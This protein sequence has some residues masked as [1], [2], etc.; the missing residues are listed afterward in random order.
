M[1]GK[2]DLG[3]INHD[4]MRIQLHDFGCYKDKTFEFGRE[5]SM[6]LLS[7]PSGTGKTTLI[8]AVFFALFGEGKKL[9]T[10]GK[11]SCTVELDFGDMK[12]FRS[13][14]PNRLVLNDIYEDEAAQQIINKRFGD[15]FKTSGYIQQNMMSSFLMMPANEKL[16]FLEKFGFQDT[17]PEKIKTKCKIYISECRDKHLSKLTQL[18]MTKNILEELDLP[19]EVKFPIKCT[20]KNRQMVIKNERTRYKNSL[21][22]YERASK[23]RR[24]YEKEINALGILEATLQSRKEVR[25]NALIKLEKIKDEINEQNYEGSEKL[26][27]YEER[28]ESLLA[29]RE[30]I[31]LEEQLD[32][33]LLRLEQMKEEE[34]N[35][36]Q[37]ELDNIQDGIW[38]EYDQAEIKN[39]I[40]ELKACLNDLE[41][42]KRLQADVDN[43]RVNLESHDKRKLELENY[44]QQLESS[45]LLYNKL[46][47]ETESYVC[48]CCNEKLHIV[49]NKLQ[50]VETETCEMDDDIDLVDLEV[51]IADYKNIINKLQRIIPVEEEKLKNKLE[52]EDQINKIMR[53]Y[54]DVPTIQEVSDDL[55][56]LREYY[57]SQMELEKKVSKLKKKK[58]SEQFSS[59]YESFKRNVDQLQEQVTNLQKK[60]CKEEESGMNEEELRNKIIEQK[61]I[62][63]KIQ[64]LVKN[65][66]NLEAEV[67]NYTCI[68]DKARK[69]HTETYGSIKNE[70]ELS[71]KIKQ[72]TKN[73]EEQELKRKEHEKNLRQIEDWEK[74]QKELENYHSWEVKVENLEKEE[75]QA[76]NEYAAS[77]ELRDKI[78]E[79]E[80]VALGNLIESINTHARGYLDNFFP[81]HPILVELQPFKETKN[82]TKPQINI[83]IEYK[84]MEADLSMLSGGELSRV[85]LAYTIALAE[86]FNIPLLMLD[87]CTA[88]LD[89][90][91]TNTVFETIRENFNGKITLIIAHQIIKGQ[92]DKVINLT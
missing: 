87:E 4:F 24:K 33:N 25:D 48:P 64:E 49:D 53:S 66:E 35:D 40:A 83:S 14:A 17:D 15:T 36:I 78:I 69:E 85:N 89:E 46:N 63:N 37:R 67:K 59:S 57:A 80:A 31:L 21:T 77:T 27:E 88:S 74:Y 19:S 18:D 81:D 38:K 30:L 54:E 56:Y 11:K 34:R 26:K 39:N 6:V 41:T 22:R 58:D 52:L 70:D 42:V 73:I 82:N 76:R 5:D 61:Y 10:H 45:Q 50:V 28:L 3:T 43:C 91:L 2:D 7:G 1:I 71:E 75:K 47:I 92:F 79:A 72:E 20:E 23:S 86:M 65:Q 84:G 62:K 16:S 68:L 32:D 60:G 51:K 12:I 29:K 8:R 13:K 44:I 90:E 55:E 9:P